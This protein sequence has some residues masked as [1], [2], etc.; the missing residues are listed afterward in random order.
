ME[1]N[2]KKRKQALLAIFGLILLAITLALVAPEEETL[3][4][5]IKLIYIHAATTWVGLLMFA[6][7]GVLALLFFVGRKSQ[8][9]I[10]SWSSASQL[11]A[12]IFW[13]GH[14]TLGSVAAY[15]SWGPGWWVEPRLRVAL[16]ILV[17]SFTAFQVRKTINSKAQAALLNLSLPVAAFGFL[18]ATG[19]LVH[20]DNAFAKSDSAEIKLFAGL[21]TVVFLA[22][23]Y[24]STRLLFKK[25]DAVA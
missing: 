10:L 24:L 21:I 22:V 14:V 20:P 4:S 6:I 16:F 19:K 23:S 17:L 2:P 18:A 3:G 11:T 15:L 9:N 12:T 7:S 25:E 1:F 5:I 8:A 13:M